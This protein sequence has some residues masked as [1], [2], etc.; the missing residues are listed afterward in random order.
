MLLLGR[1]KYGAVMQLQRPEAP[2]V[3]L[4]DFATIRFEAGI[5]PSANGVRAWVLR[6]N[7]QGKRHPILAPGGSLFSTYGCTDEALAGITAWLKVLLAEE[8][9]PEIAIVSI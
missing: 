4:I 5:S 2:K 9:D 8:T 3:Y 7:E 6:L 1:S